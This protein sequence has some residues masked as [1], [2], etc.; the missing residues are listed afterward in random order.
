MVLLAGG[1]AANSRLRERLV[2]EADGLGVRVLA[3]S[4]ALCTD[5]GAMVACAGSFALERGERTPLD[6][7]ADPN[8]QIVPGVG[9][10]APRRAKHRRR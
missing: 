3:P 4:P 5:N 1:V 9:R 7:R 6:A 8:L 10:R 2:K